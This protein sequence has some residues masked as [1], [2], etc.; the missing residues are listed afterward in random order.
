MAE[1]RNAQEQTEQDNFGRIIADS[2]TS[3]AKY[4]NAPIPCAR[5]SIVQEKL[6]PH[7]PPATT[8]RP[9]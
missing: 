8:A 5:E 4:T 6:N 7:Y 3:I 2:N 1:Q 9:S